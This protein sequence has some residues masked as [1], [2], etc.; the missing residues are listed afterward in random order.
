MYSPNTNSFD[1]LSSDIR[2]IEPKGFNEFGFNGCSDTISP[3]IDNLVQTESL[4]LWNNYVFKVCSPSRAAFLSGRYPATLGLQNLVFNQEFPLSLTRQVSTISEEF[5]A[6]QYTT[7]MI[8][9]LYTFSVY[10]QIRVY[11]IM[12]HCTFKLNMF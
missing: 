2:C 5:K 7:H 6:A 8:G 10:S 9:Y 12:S 3:V 4:L 1:L 11:I